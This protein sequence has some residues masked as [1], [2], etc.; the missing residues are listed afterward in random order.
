MM[1][2]MKKLAS[3]ALHTPGNPVGGGQCRRAG[4]E[5]GFT[6]IEMMVSLAIAAL[7]GLLAV[8]WVRS[9]LDAAQLVSASNVFVA[10]LQLARSEAIK[11]NHRVVLCKAAAIS[12]ASTGGWE[13]GWII[14]HDANDNG[15]RD[16]TEAILHR[17]MALPAGLRLS[18]NM[19]VAA[20]VSFMPTGGTKQ[21]SG[22]F[23]AGTLTLCHRS[24]PNRD[25]RHIVLNAA[26]RPR[27]HK[28]PVESCL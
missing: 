23:Q 14:F 3:R 27:V 16:D 13:Q 19:P 11:R 18:G 25:A 28:S 8:P 5:A 6:L 7:L 9:F 15:A 24:L 21:L 22:G 17:Q 12:C 10:S 4:S 1:R 26:G 2:R 20:Y